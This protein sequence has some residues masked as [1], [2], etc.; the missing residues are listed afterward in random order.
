MSALTPDRL[1]ELLA[2]HDDA[3]SN[4]CFAQFDGQHRAFKTKRATVDR[5]NRLI[6]KA[7]FNR[8]PTEDEAEACQAFD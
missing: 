3:I 8:K 2:R 6:F 5:I 7:V 4:L 1:C